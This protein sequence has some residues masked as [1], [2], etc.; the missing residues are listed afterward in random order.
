MAPIQRLDPCW[1]FVYGQVAIAAFSARSTLLVSLRGSTGQSS[2]PGRWLLDRPVNSRIKSGEGDHSA[3]AGDL[4]EK[5]G[6]PPTTQETNPYYGRPSDF[7][8]PARP[9]PGHCR[10]PSRPPAITQKT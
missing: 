9:H 4:I 7:G 5:R 6:P 2:I 3:V 10:R 8:N 1:S